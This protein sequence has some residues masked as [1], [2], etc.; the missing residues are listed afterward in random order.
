ML[1]ASVG[2]LA[3]NPHHGI[4]WSQLKLI[5]LFWRKFHLCSKCSGPS[6]LREAINYNHR[7]YLGEEDRML[8]TG[9]EDDDPSEGKEN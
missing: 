3:A 7:G 9:W 5:S 8:S 1:L 2:S 6:Q 4:I